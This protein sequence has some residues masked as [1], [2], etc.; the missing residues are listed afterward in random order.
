MRVKIEA[1]S[2][3]VQVSDL[4]ATA[5]YAVGALILNSEANFGLFL[6]E[7]KMHERC[8]AMC[9]VI[10]RSM[11]APTIMTLAEV[12]LKISRSFPSEKSR[13]CMSLQRNTGA[14]LAVLHR[15]IGEERDPYLPF[16]DASPP[17]ADVVTLVDCVH[18]KV[19][20]KIVWEDVSNL[21]LGKRSVTAKFPSNTIFATE[22]GLWFTCA[23][24]EAEDARCVR[25][26]V[27]MTDVLSVEI[28][29]GDSSTCKVSL[30]SALGCFGNVSIESATSTVH[31]VFK[32]HSNAKLFVQA[33][34][35]KL[36]LFKHLGESE[37]RSALRCISSA[38]ARIAAFH[39]A[40]QA[41]YDGHPA[42]VQWLYLLQQQPVSL[43]A[44]ILQST[45]LFANAPR[46]R[47]EL[48]RI[49][50]AE[51]EAACAPVTM[52]MAKKA[53]QA[54]ANLGAETLFSKISA[55][56]SAIDSVAKQLV[57]DFQNKPDK[58]IA[59]ILS[60]VVEA[61]G[62]PS[63]KVSI[64]VE[65]ILSAQPVQFIEIMCQNIKDV[66]CPTPLSSRPKNVRSNFRNFWLKFIREAE[67]MLS[68]NEGRFFQ[69]HEWLSTLSSSKLI[70]LRLAATEASLLVVAGL[71]EV[72]GSVA[73]I[74]FVIARPRVLSHVY[75]YSS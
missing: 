49:M 48:H 19:R 56:A 73:G 70:S 12:I 38:S 1:F 63:S 9:N 10:S 18:N 46:F 62:M 8:D 64:S 75:F 33:L 34:Q 40:V 51:D 42:Y 17:A 4:I 6:A 47:R 44:V 24:D 53:S 41:V 15:V 28:D 74:F 7:Q 52:P 50:S 14:D 72:A 13:L 61:A 26:C 59:D 22:L 20:G 11:H 30:H 58:G 35:H 57:G 21:K 71:A 55:S 16:K 66:E 39:D 69:L 60:L 23:E 2:V 54:I 36:N 43:D 65:D 32:S 31:V 29:R 68:E 37:R 45:I 25:A 3:N 5:A 67:P 27:N